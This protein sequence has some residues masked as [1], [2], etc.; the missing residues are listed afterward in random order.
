MNS[1]NKGV[2]TLSYNFLMADGLSTT[3][4]LVRSLT[5]APDAPATIV[6]HDRSKG[7]GAQ[8][9]CDRANRGELVLASDLLFIGDAWKDVNPSS[10]A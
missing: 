4:V 7:E 9:V 2:E 3:G 6:L 8:I 5:A 10:Y 1:K